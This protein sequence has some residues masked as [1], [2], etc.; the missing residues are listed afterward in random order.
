MN[1]NA[2]KSPYEK[3]VIYNKRKILFCSEKKENFHE[4]LNCRTCAEDMLKTHVEGGLN[5][6]TCAEDIG[7]IPNKRTSMQ[8]SP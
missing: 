8:N 1:L 7:Y 4:K 2:K 6:R 5:C 3:V